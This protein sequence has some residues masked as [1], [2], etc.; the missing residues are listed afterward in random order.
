MN[1]AR[2][3]LGNYGEKLVWRQY[4]QAGFKLL[5]RQF[6]C[7]YGEIDLIL[8]KDNV[9]YFVEVRTKTGWRYGPAEESITS[10]KKRTIRKVSQFYLNQYHIESHE[11]VGIQYDVVCVYIQKQTKQAWIKRYP[12]AF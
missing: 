7:R 9:L 12:Q 3:K 11:E 8:Q 2:K 4:E 10:K 6:R 5:E 1:D